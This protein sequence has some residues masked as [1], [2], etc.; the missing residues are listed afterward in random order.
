[1]TAP[2]HQHAFAQIKELQPDLLICDLVFDGTPAGWALI[3][4]VV[5]DPTTT[6]LPILLCSAATR[7]LQEAAGSLDAKGILW[8]EKP[9]TLDQL[10]EK[11][12]AALKRRPRTSLPTTG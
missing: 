2:K 3:D 12:T 11:V 1:M 6:E 4:M 8:L 10:L 9:F 7:Q 5:L